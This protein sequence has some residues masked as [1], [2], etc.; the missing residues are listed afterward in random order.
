MMTP[1]AK[2]LFHRAIPM[3]GTGFIK[4]WS[5]ADKPEL[6]ERLAMAL[7]WDGKDGE[8]GILDTLENTSVKDIVEAESKLLTNEEKFTE[9]IYFPFTPVI[10]P[11]VNERTFLPKDPVLLGREAWSNDIDSIIGGTSLEGGMM[12]MSFKEVERNFHEFF[13][14]PAAFTLTRELGLDMTKQSDKQKASKYGERLKKFYFG[15]GPITADMRDQYLLVMRTM[16][17]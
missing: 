13:H 8:K 6:T 5:F 4:A 11:Y 10:E 7:G 14:D 17:F 15:E 12:I 2:G 16:T 9:H 3:S 1:L